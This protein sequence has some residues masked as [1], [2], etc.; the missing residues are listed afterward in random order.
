M[1]SVSFGMGHEGT[2]PNQ[3]LIQ[4]LVVLIEIIAALG[5]SKKGHGGNLAYGTPPKKKQKNK[6]RRGRVEAWPMDVRQ[7][8][9]SQLRGANFETDSL[10]IPGTGSQKKKR[11]APVVWNRAPSSFVGPPKKGGSPLGLSLNPEKPG[12]GGGGGGGGGS[13]MSEV[14]KGP[15]HSDPKEISAK[16]LKKQGNSW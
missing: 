5:G 1:A 3:R 7:L 16:S 12:G 10:Q 8:R 11:K 2:S 13:L 15:L 14:S 4:L 9:V 6:R